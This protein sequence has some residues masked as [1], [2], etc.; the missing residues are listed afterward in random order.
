MNK[1]MSVYPQAVEHTKI[2]VLEDMDRYLETLDTLP[3]FEKYISDRVNYLEQIWMNVWLNKVTNDISKK[4]KKALLQERNYEVEG[5]DKKILNR[6][7]RN[8]MRDFKPFQVLE[9]LKKLYSNDL[10]GWEDK[11]R[12]AKEKYA[13]FLDEEEKVQKR[14]GIQNGVVAALNKLMEEQELT[15]YLYIRHRVSVKLKN[16]L[17]TKPKY[18]IIDTVRIEEQLESIGPFNPDDY[19]TV[20]KF[21]D[22]L[23]GRVHKAFYWEYESYFYE[24]DHFLS[25]ILL[26]RVSEQVIPYIADDIITEYHELYGEPLKA[27][28][29]K[30]IVELS[31]EHW[32][33]KYFSLIQSELFQDLLRL[34]EV[35]YDPVE[36]EKRYKQDLLDREQKKQEEE[37]EIR[38]KQEEETRIL[39]DIFGREYRP[40]AGRSISYVLHIGETNTGKTHHALERMMKAKSGLYLAPLRLLALE[41]YDKLNANG[42]PCALKTGEEEK[43][44]A[45]AK[46]HSCTV[47]MFYEKESYDVIVIDESQMIADKDRGFSWYK[48]IT[49]ANADEVHIIG[50]RNVEKM[51]LQLLGDAE[52]VEIFD[53]SRDIPLK[54]ERKE[55]N[56]NQTK[57]GDA[58]VCFSRRRVLETA[59]RLQ[60]NGYSVSMI[61]GSMPPETRKKQMQRFIDGE[62]TVIVST[63]AIGMG[64]N[65]PIRRI[66]F[67]EN[68]KFDGSRRRRL[69]SQEVKQIAGRAGRKGLYDVG[70]VAFSADIK[71]MK[72]LLQKEDDS[73]QTFAIAPTTSVFERFQKYYRDLGTFFE[74]WEKFDSPKGTKKAS[75]SEERELYESIKGTEI[76]AR[77][78]MMDLYGFLHL[79]F[80]TKDPGLVEQWQEKMRAIVKGVELP[81]PQ[82]TTGTL[83]EMELSYKSIGLHLLFLYRLDQRTEAIYWERVREE[84]SDGVHEYLKNDV[85]NLTKKCKHCGQRL[86]W[87]HAFTI[88]DSC[89]VSRHKKRDQGHYR[90]RR[91]YR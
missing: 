22:E 5:I 58:L 11:Y 9:W 25:Y 44:V 53:Y 55:F 41:V 26:E 29:V 67:L 3:P 28:K 60:K 68:D 50:S 72:H 35:A 20:S 16:D 18:K 36:H 71:L 74:L 12:K 43:T 69:T 75:L 13:Q 21:F 63:D 38:K 2:K 80:S 57:N 14:K 10:K 17:T 6:L 84:I 85:K 45:G 31:L 64:L 42:V 34:S 8:E 90:N 81:E 24:Y 19:F 73:I 48:A 33:K 4:E 15:T 91:S 62:T 54:V 65:L 66:A 79:P 27:S 30:G 40:S 51:I 82:I 77:L 7:F 70:K 32:H 87:D 39:D 78:S 49:K 83:E 61:Y 1:L 47:E 37:E 52:N 46:H 89:Y 88:C 23:T 86:H 56:M 59:S 76:E